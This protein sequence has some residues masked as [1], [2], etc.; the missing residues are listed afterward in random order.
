MHESSSKVATGTSVRTMHSVDAVVDV[1]DV[2]GET[3]DTVVVFVVVFVVATAVLLVVA[4]GES[5][6][7]SK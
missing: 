6:A 4:A 2:V 3:F 1:E 5:I 7:G